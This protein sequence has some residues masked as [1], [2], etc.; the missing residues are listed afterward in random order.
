MVA[1]FGTD[2][3]VLSRRKLL[4]RNRTK[5]SRAKKVALNKIA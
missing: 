2:D 5:K 1:K 3:P 4:Q